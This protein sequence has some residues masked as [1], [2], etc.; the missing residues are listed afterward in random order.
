M[1]TNGSTR[2]AS[3]PWQALPPSISDLVRPH[4]DEL[5]DRIIEAVS[6]EVTEYARPLEGAFGRGVRHG[7]SVAL[8]RFLELPG[9]R[10]PA[11]APKTIDV[12][13]L[14][15]AGEMREQRAMDSLLTAYRVGA[16]VTFRNVSR[17]AI[18]AGVSIEVI[19]SLGE[20]IFAY[21]DEIAAV[22]VE[23]YAFEQSRQAGENERRRAELVELLLAGADEATIRQ[24]CAAVGWELPERLV[25]VT[26]PRDKAE[27]VHVRLG[28]DCLVLERT[29]D[30]IALI[31][32]STS[33]RHIAQRERQL[34]NRHAVVGVGTPWSRVAHSL[35]TASAA[36]DM[37]APTATV[38]YASEHLAQI[39]IG[40]DAVTVGAIA[41]QRLAPLD[42]LREGSREKL[43][44]TLL[45]W[46]RHRGQREAIADELN[47]HPQTVGYRVNQ[48]RELFG[49]DLTDPDVRFELELALRAGHR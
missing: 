9:T 7:T 13:R 37:V 23:G 20:S 42:T 33:E 8:H 32:S 41:A 39:A 15:G 5:A 28:R 19:V 47:V 34:A 35:R 21:I 38:V 25:A 31:P 4:L 29:A 26:M 24:Q 49:S 3:P 14:L 45:S 48:L 40:S 22:S 17:F 6:Q 10:L 36:R 30:V 18:D 46:L 43:A 1:V 16:R 2:P 11:L 12:Y 44:E 27:G